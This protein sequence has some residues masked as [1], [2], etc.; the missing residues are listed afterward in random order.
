MT[1]WE[2]VSALVQV[3]GFVGIIWGLYLN[4]RALQTQVAMEFYGRV[5]DI[6]RRMPSEMRLAKY[7]GQR[8]A[9]LSEDQKTAVALS[10]IEYLNLCSEE[11]ALYRSGR[12]GTDMWNVSRAEIERNFLS[13]LWRDVWTHIRT[14]YESTKEFLTYVDGLVS[15]SSP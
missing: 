1:V 4:W 15:S 2:P 10:L 11:F 7:S 3:F 14:E 8:F 13:P 12:L 6:L 9:R 5:S